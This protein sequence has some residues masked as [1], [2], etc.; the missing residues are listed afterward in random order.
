M[1]AFSEVHI[2]KRQYS[3]VENTV[4]ENTVFREHILP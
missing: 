3:C 4:F 2:L 1:I